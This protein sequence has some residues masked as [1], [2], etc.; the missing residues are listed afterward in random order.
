MD[1]DRSNL[2][3]MVV[4]LLYSR[5]QLFDMVRCCA[6]ASADDFCRPVRCM[7][8][9]DTGVFRVRVDPADVFI[10]VAGVAIS[11]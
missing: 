9:I 10:R 7:F 3:N 1:E 4:N 6:A 11:N 2:S 5:C 8:A